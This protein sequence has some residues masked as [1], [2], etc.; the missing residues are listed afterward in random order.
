MKKTLMLI[1]ML[2]LLTGCIAGPSSSSIGIEKKGVFDWLPFVGNKVAPM[3][4]AT[5]IDI[6]ET[7]MKYKT[8]IPYH[9]VALALFVFSFYITV[10]SRTNTGAGI[11]GFISAGGLS[12]FAYAVPSNDALISW[13]LT[14]AAVLAGLYIAATHILP[15]ITKRKRKI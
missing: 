7:Q 9:Y 11:I 8:F 10:Y 1:P 13:V 14:I 12:L 2:L 15:F 4:E 3:E 6:A 5:R